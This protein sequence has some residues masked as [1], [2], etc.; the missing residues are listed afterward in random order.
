MLSTPVYDLKKQKI[1]SLELLDSVFGVTPKPHLLNAAVRAQIAWRHAQK[2]ANSRTRTEVSGTRKKMYKQKGTGR[3][4]HG[5]MKA[6]I[7]VGGGK[8]HG[9]RPRVVSHKINRKVMRGA[10]LT[11]LTLSQQND[12]LFIIENLGCEKPNTK[13]VLECGMAFKADRGLFINCADTDAEKAFNR[14]IA[15]AKR[16]KFL[17]PEGINVF[18]ILKFENLFVSRKAVERLTERLTNGT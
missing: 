14:S 13:L 10:L 4:R 7:F 6:P 16:Y 3:A 1:G 2:T 8:A 9:P 17:R 5:D 11:A 18:D 15:N 12:R